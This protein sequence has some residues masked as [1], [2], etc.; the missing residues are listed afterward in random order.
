MKL[1]QSTFRR[2]QETRGHYPE[3]LIEAA[4]ERGVPSVLETAERG[5]WVEDVGLDL[6]SMNIQR[7]PG[8]PSARHM[9]L[10]EL[11]NTRGQR[12][13]MLPL[14][15]APG[16]LPEREDCVAAAR[17]HPSSRRLGLGS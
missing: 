16:E 14:G 17:P 13:V 9:V 12:A 8:D 6:D 10:Q 15:I 1:F 4:I 2:G 5:L 11:R 3:P 7:D